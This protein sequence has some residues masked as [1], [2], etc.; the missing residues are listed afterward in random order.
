MR[1]ESAILCFVSDIKSKNLNVFEKID[2][3]YMTLLRHN[4]KLYYVL[5]SLMFVDFYAY[6]KHHIHTIEK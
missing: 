3:L 5:F 2:N 6:P 1:G 4:L